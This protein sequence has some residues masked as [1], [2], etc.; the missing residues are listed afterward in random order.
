ME[1]LTINRAICLVLVGLLLAGCAQ[2]ET[3]IGIE[4]TGPHSNVEFDAVRVTCAQDTVYRPLVSNGYGLSL[5]CGSASGF[6]AVSLLRF[7]PSSV[8]PDSFRVDSNRL[9]LR[10]VATLP[11]RAQGFICAAIRLVTD[12]WSEDSVRFDNL[13]SYETYPFIQRLIHLGSEP[14]DSL[15]SRLPDSLVESWIQDDTLNWGIWIEDEPTDCGSFLREFYSGESGIGYAPAL[16][17]YGG[18]YDTN[19]QGEWVESPLDTFVGARDDAY[20][21]WD[22][23]PPIE[24][25]MALTQGVSQRLLLYFPLENALPSF[26]ASVVHAE[27]TLWADNLDEANFGSVTLL[28]H[29]TLKT[30]SWMTDPDSTVTDQISVTSSAFDVNNE[31]VVF[32]VT[33]LVSDWVQEP[34]TNC[35]FFIASSAEAQALGRRIFYNRLASDTTVVPELRIWFATIQ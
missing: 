21:A 18:R 28:K 14:A 33:V 19:D 31:K 26:G 17:L 3:S 6:R 25:R 30:K 35:G 29:G 11:E 10:G 22:T 23:Q 12:P 15:Q 16:Y 13:P 9:V 1:H 5:Q 20:L 27:L 32:D 24:G 2:R 34:E 7:E 4:A 8:L